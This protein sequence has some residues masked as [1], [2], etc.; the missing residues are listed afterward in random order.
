[1]A[2]LLPLS[3]SIKGQNYKTISGKV[4]DSA[5]QPISFA[6]I[7]LSTKSGSTSIITDNEGIF[8]FKNINTGFF[9]I[10]IKMIGYKSITTSFNYQGEKKLIVIP[11]TTLKEESRQ[12][13]DV[14]IIGR[15]KIEL[16]ED[17]IQFNTDQIKVGRGKYAADVIKSIPGTI[18]T[19]N[20]QLMYLGIPIE[21][22][23]INGK[24]YLDGDL[25]TIGNIFPLS[26][27]DNVQIIN[28]YGDLAN[29]T[30]NKRGSANKIINI[31]LKDG[32]K[33]GI[34][35][36]ALLSGGN[37]D[38]Y[39]AEIS[40]TLQLKEQQFTVLGGINNTNLIKGSNGVSGLTENSDG[41]NTTTSTAI[42]YRNNHSESLILYGSVQLRNQEQHSSQN[43]FRETYYPNYSIYNTESRSNANKT[44]SKR[45][46]FNVE[47]KFSKND[48][49]KISPQLESDNLSNLGDGIIETNNMNLIS[50]FRNHSL[51]N[52]DIPKFGGS[53]LYNH[54]FQK[55][56]RNLSV[57]FNSQKSKENIYREI[58]NNQIVNPELSPGQITNSEMHQNITN[59]NLSYIE[60]VAKHSFFDFSISLNHTSKI[61]Q[62]KTDLY[63]LNN[64][65]LPVE[66]SL[67]ERFSSDFSNQTINGG[68]RYQNK[69]FSASIGFNIINSVLKGKASNKELKTANNKTDYAPNVRLNYYLSKTKTITLEYSGNSASPE[70]EQ[71]MPIRD[72]QNVQNIIIGNA[73][74]RPEFR[75]NYKLY[76]NTMNIETGSSAFFGFEYNTVNNKII[77]DRFSNQETLVQT[78]SYKNVDG[79]RSFR[80][81]YSITKAINESKFL[82][83]LNGSSDQSNNI[84]ILNDVKSNGSNWLFNQQIQLRTVFGN[85][86]ENQISIDYSLN[87]SRYPGNNNASTSSSIRTGTN[88]ALGLS[89][90]LALGYDIYKQFNSGYTGISN[91]NP[92]IINLNVEL[93]FLKNKSA[94]IKMS[95]MDLL[96]QNIG[97][98]RDVMSNTISNYKSERLSRYFLLT[99]KYSFQKT[100]LK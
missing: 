58:M 68:Y 41:L 55:I 78:T 23:K 7:K 97:V 82:L 26:L 30:G 45:I 25:Q 65:P 35:G 83:N 57:N 52:S 19:P 47:Y 80:V 43:I 87:K 95:G 92:L 11:T 49:L 12:L 88:G 79:F 2:M 75:N 73:D 70:I 27:I 3:L 84:S 74:L 21:K 93:S 69:N 32:F 10:N 91:T 62:I 44:K 15:K 1:M 42:N 51:N 64:A 67:H 96:N 100:D 4:V 9:D 89:K 98:Y 50:N 66:K 53:I 17:T 63:D 34:F 86:F 29:I 20:G 38:R 81:F 16:K 28:D 8:V 6:T 54:R 59:L 56:G 77:Q 76:Y 18:I 72:I 33:N 99:L 13:N 31:N 40:S 90:N 22:I 46:S 61:N 39:Q 71:L 94:S 14:V 60:P 24:D 5:K 37:L 85:Q 48:F 36:S